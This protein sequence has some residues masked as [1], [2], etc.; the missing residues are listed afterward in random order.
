MDNLTAGIFGF[1]VNILIGFWTRDFYTYFFCNIW[2]TI[3]AITLR[4][5]LEKFRDPA[6]ILIGFQTSSTLLLYVIFI[7]FDFVFSFTGSYLSFLGIPISYLLVRWRVLKLYS[8]RHFKFEELLCMEVFF[9]ISIWLLGSYYLALL[10]TLAGIALVYAV[11]YFALHENHLIF[12]FNLLCALT[13]ALALLY[14][15]CKL[16]LIIAS[17]VFNYVLNLSFVSYLNSVIFSY[18][19]FL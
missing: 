9:H 14:Y 19:T 2:T 5:F 10:D 11:T 1:L 12:L 6:K 18:L 17:A 8:S 15:V 4:Q 16:I 13:P 3:Q 7:G